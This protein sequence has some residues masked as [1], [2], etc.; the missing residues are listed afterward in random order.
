MFCA[1]RSGPGDL[2]QGREQLPVQ[3]HFGSW[4]IAVAGFV[5]D[6][7]CTKLYDAAVPD[8]DDAD[9]AAY[10]ADVP[11]RQGA[12]PCTYGLPAKSNEAKP[13]HVGRCSFQIGK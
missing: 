1:H 5:C 10:D 13:S 11:A 9:D 8:D 3:E 4:A 7:V 2:G 12:R 6:A